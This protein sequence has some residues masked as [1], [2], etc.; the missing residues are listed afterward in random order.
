MCLPAL[1]LTLS[2][3]NERARISVNHSTDAENQNDQ[4]VDTAEQ[5]A[6]GLGGRERLSTT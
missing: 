2:L 6:R 3:A 1:I 4:E 5:K